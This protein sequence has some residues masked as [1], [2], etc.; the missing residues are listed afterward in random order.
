[1]RAPCVD[2]LCV[3]L[4]R[5]DGRSQA[6]INTAQFLDA[7]RS[8]VCFTVAKTLPCVKEKH[9]AIDHAR[10]RRLTDEVMGVAGAIASEPSP[11][12]LAIRVLIN[13]GAGDQG[14]TVTSPQP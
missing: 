11:L 3:G 10:E 12:A 5:G 14:S 13:G 1:M 7:R 8:D 2:L 4:T 6:H 9:V